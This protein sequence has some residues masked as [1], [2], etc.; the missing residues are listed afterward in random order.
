MITGVAAYSLAKEWLGKKIDVEHIDKL[1]E[2]QNDLKIN[3][4]GEGGEFETFV[5]DSPMHK[6]SI[7]IIKA[8]KLCSEHT[9]T[10]KIKEIIL[11][12]K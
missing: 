1:K 12:D 5:I 9:G 2:L 4:A 8:E 6:K 10:L 11:V 7:K 3:P